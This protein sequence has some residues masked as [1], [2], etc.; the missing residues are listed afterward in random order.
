MRV[1]LTAIL[2]VSGLGAAA[3]GYALK[4]VLNLPRASTLQF[5]RNVKVEPDMRKIIS[6]NL[7][8][9]TYFGAF[10]VHPS[11][12][13]GYASEANSMEAAEASALRF[14]ADVSFDDGQC[15]IAARLLPKGL[16]PDEYPPVSP[17]IS[18]GIIE[19]DDLNELGYAA[20]AASGDGAVR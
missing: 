1:I 7:R 12:A 5:D 9:A 8:E 15:R 19:V 2:C 20:V 13:Y 11:S 17:A 16:T 6:D 18:D 4:E 14:C 10:A 3:Q